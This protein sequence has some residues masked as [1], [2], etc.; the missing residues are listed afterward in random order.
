VASAREWPRG[1]PRPAL[2]GPAARPEPR[3]VARR[4]R[5]VGQQLRGQARLGQAAAA[6]IAPLLTNEILSPVTKFDLDNIC[7]GEESTPGRVAVAAPPR[8][9]VSPSACAR[10][11]RGRAGRRR[12]RP[13]AGP[14]APRA[15]GQAPAAGG[16]PGEGGGGHHALAT[17]LR[18]MGIPSTKFSTLYGTIQLASSRQA[19]RV[20]G[21]HR[22]AVGGRGCGVDGQQ[23]VLELAEGDDRVRVRPDVHL[24][25]EGGRGKGGHRAGRQRRHRPSSQGAAESPPASARQVHARAGQC[26]ARAPRTGRTAM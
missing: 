18:L 13:A 3:V 23:E 17:Q 20:A 15:G 9:P 8:G 12:G 6:A 14:A 2:V 21:S 26:W 10:A 25:G 24:P 5:G 4:P 11:R 7:G 16:G 19:S 1:W 22:Q